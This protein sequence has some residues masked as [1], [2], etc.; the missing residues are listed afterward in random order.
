[1]LSGTFIS[2]TEWPGAPRY[3]KDHP[4]LTFVNS[5]LGTF[6]TD[7]RTLSSSPLTTWPIPSLARAKST[8]LGTFDLGH[9]LPPPTLIDQDCN[10]HREFPKVLQKPLEVLG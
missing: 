9:F 2:Y 6:D 7:L 4:N 5:D 10:V 1:M 8:W 3:E